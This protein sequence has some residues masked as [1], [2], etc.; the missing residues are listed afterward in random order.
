[1]G[2]IRH[3]AHH[4]PDTQ[5]AVIRTQILTPPARNLV[6]PTHGSRIRL[7]RGG[8]HLARL[9][10]VFGPLPISAIDRTTVEEWTTRRRRDL[11]PRTSRPISASTINREIDLLKSVL[12]AAVPRYLPRSP[13]YGLRR[14]RVVKPKRRILTPQEER[15]L[16]AALEVN[17]RALLIAGMDTLCRLRNLLDL[18]WK[19]LDLCRRVIFIRAPKVRDVSRPH[20]VPMSK[21]LFDAIKR[22]PRVSPYVFAHRRLAKTDRD[23][24][25]TIRQPME[26]PCRAAKISYGRD[27]GGITFHWAT[28]RTGATRMLLAKVPVPTVQQL[29]HW[30]RPRAAKL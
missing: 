9:S 5:H 6:N 18:R 1:M 23:R 24:R 8:R 4:A 13:L 26:R 29:G 30:A 2:R 25:N 21:R 28:R 12:Q 11:V 20:E 10:R 17:D 19:D 3:L 22:L 27:A 7:V 16:L 14:L 15:R